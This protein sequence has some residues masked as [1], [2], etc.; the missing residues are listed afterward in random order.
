M[1]IVRPI[2]SRVIDTSCRQAGGQNPNRVSIIEPHISR[3]RFSTKST[4]ANCYN[5]QAVITALAG[6]SLAVWIVT[7]Q[8][9]IT[10]IVFFACLPNSTGAVRVVASSVGWSLAG[11][12]GSS[13]TTCQTANGLRRLQ[14]S[15]CM[16]QSVCVPFRWPM[17][18]GRGELCRAGGHPPESRPPSPWKQHN[19]H[20][21][22]GP[23]GHSLSVFF[24]GPSGTPPPLA[25]QALRVF[26]RYHA[27][28]TVSVGHLSVAIPA[29]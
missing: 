25:G 19:R 15:A 14:F 29:V 21:P 17:F 28:K 11:C 20:A 22:M 27:F 5:L 18:L 3:A 7:T 12:D 24:V 16:R 1:P 4:E 23:P 2:R 9:I 6:P 13:R 10:P 8:T 26:R